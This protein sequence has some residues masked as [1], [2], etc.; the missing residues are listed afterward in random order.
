MYLNKHK[1]L[2]YNEVAFVTVGV[3][4]P[5]D[6]TLHVAIALHCDLVLI[7]ST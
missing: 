7:A 3:S 6:L 5:G 2:V 4:G 1:Q